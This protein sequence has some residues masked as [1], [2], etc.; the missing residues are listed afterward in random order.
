MRIKG[1]NEYKAFSLV[2][3]NV[4]NFKIVIILFLNLVLKRIHRL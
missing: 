1:D 2:D 3:P 4:N